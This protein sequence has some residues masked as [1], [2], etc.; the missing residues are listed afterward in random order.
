MASSFVPRTRREGTVP[1]AVLEA[2]DLWR[3]YPSGEGQVHAVAEVNLAVAAGEF[4]ALTGRSGSGKTTLLNL[5][6]G[7]DWQT[8]G[9]V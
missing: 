3:T 5:L 2:R 4:V 8:H 7:L 6:G 1:E 9:S